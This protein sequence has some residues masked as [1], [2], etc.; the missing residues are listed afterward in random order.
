MREYITLMTASL[1]K[2][3]E[4]F[5]VN[6]WPP[7]V[8]DLRPYREKFGK[9]EFSVI[10]KVKEDGIFSAY[11]EKMPSKKQDHQGR[12]MY[13]VVTAQGEIGSDVAKVVKILAA[14]A[15]TDLTKLGEKFDEKFSTEYIATF[16]DC[17]HT[18]ETESEIQ[19][20]LILLANSLTVDSVD[21][22]AIEP[23]VVKIGQLDAN[24]KEFV[25]KLD[26]LDSDTKLDGITILVAC[27]NKFTE[28]SINFIKNGIESPAQGLILSENNQVGTKKVEKKKKMSSRLMTE[29]SINSS[30]FS[31]VKKKKI[32]STIC[33]LSLLLN[34]VVV[35]CL[36]SSRSSVKSLTTDLKTKDSLLK[37]AKE[38]IVSL[39]SLKTPSFQDT[40][41]LDVETF[42]QSGLLKTYTTM[43]DS[44]ARYNYA[45]K[46]ASPDTIIICR[47][48]VEIFHNNVDKLRDLENVDK[49]Y[50]LFADFNEKL[51]PYLAPQ[52][53]QNP[54]ASKTQSRNS[55]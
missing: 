34:I 14:A 46:V 8:E 35:I 36:M 51:Q 29:S 18:P 47:D 28:D 45:F 50:K 17:R 24:T 27:N 20:K 52:P 5:S 15:V 2:D 4:Y 32:N 48:G 7:S 54:T 30:S 22:G 16:D 23:S 39:E 41:I 42:A 10:V 55:K 53:S 1:K 26:V 6:A 9:S 11:I 37:S 40:I 43:T 49:M 12:S 25:S 13:Y 38:Q 44:A 21:K 3:F 19:K 31:P 33:L